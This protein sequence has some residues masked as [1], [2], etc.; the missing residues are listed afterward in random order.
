[1]SDVDI[2]WLFHWPPTPVEFAIC[3]VLAVACGLLWGYVIAARKFGHGLEGWGKEMRG[4]NARVEQIMREPLTMLSRSSF[5]VA[6]CPEC[7]VPWPTYT[8]SDLRLME[9]LMELDSG[10]R[11]PCSGSG[12]ILKPAAYGENGDERFMPPP[13]RDS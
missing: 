12:R 6:R 1:M 9:H 3:I 11:V 8:R 2:A 13:R 5:R 4:H 10:V 7:K